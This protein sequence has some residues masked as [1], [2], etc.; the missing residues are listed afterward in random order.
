METNGGV[1]LPAELVQ[2]FAE[3]V[4]DGL[5]SSVRSRP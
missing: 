4:H 2:S 1:A 3:S 5:F